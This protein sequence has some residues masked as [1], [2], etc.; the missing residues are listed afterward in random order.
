MP[1]DL[2]RRV[3]AHKEKAAATFIATAST[4]SK[5]LNYRNI[6]CLRSFFALAD[7]KFHG[8]AFRKILEAFHIDSGIMYEHVF[9]ALVR[10]ESVALLSVEPLYSTFHFSFY[11]QILFIESAVT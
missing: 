3:L 4:V 10:D 2:L 9:A 1:E 11:L 7:I 5:L 6:Y 8:C